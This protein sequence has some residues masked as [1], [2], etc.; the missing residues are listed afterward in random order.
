MID[1]SDFLLQINSTGI[2]QQVATQIQDN[3]TAVTAGIGGLIATAVGVVAKTVIDRKNDLDVVSKGSVTDKIIFNEVIDNFGVLI[4]F[5][6]IEKEIQ[7]VQ[8]R[9]PNLTIMQVYDT[10]ADETTKE[11]YGQRR[12]KYMKQAIDDF[13]KYY[14]GSTLSSSDINNYS[15]NPKKILNQT[16]N[17][18]K[19]KTTPNTT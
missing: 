3:S 12:A 11:T 19:D 6:K 10:V 7:L 5:F 8:T 16:L 13:I 9:N 2:P 18:V 1:F 4:D 17:L 15:D 14:G